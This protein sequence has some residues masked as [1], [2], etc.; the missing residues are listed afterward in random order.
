MRRGGGGVVFFRHVERP[1][2]NYVEARLQWIT[3]VSLVR[4]CS[5]VFG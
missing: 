3:M 5:G 1:V 4:E 2:V